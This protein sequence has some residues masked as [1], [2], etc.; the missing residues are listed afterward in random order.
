MELII[1]NYKVYEVVVFIRPP[2]LQK[3]DI[4]FVIFIKNNHEIRIVKRYFHIL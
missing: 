1:P 4:C 2:H 3:I